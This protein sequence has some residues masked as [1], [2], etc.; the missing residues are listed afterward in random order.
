M[1]PSPSLESSENQHHIDTMKKIE[2]ILFCSSCIA[3]SLA[4]G[5]GGGVE[6][7]ATSQRSSGFQK[8][9]FMS[10]HMPFLGTLP[11]ITD[12][13]QNWCLCTHTPLILKAL[14]PSPLLLHRK[15]LPGFPEEPLGLSLILLPAWMSHLITCSI[16]TPGYTRSRLM[17]C[18][19]GGLPS[20]SGGCKVKRIVLKLPHH[21]LITY[22]PLFLSFCAP[23]RQKKFREYFGGSWSAGWV[24]G[25]HCMKALLISTQIPATD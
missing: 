19:N 3:E 11:Q 21:L 25:F 15:G 22:K 23:Q 7:D 17:R 14:S 20:A 12:K 8:G 13:A 18:C 10:S 16:Q 2:N 5:G 9:P 1:H 6:G 24:I 4:P